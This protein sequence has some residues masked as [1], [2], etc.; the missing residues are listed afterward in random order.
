MSETLIQDFDV[1][2]AKKLSGNKN[3]FWQ[4]LKPNG[5]SGV[6]LLWVD[7]DKM[8]VLSTELGNHFISFEIRDRISLFVWHLTVVYGPA[9]R[10]DKDDFLLEFAA[11]SSK[12]DGPVVMGGDFNIIRKPF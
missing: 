12:I 3:F 1:F 2:W 10:E 7:A 6:L 8:E 11:V 9:Q 5:R 4:Q